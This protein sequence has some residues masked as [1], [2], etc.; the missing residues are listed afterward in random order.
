MMVIPGGRMELY[1]ITER[2]VMIL[3]GFKFRW[4]P[5][6]LELFTEKERLI[7]PVTKLFKI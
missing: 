7:L 3:A 6:E 4:R 1:T 2:A 5:L